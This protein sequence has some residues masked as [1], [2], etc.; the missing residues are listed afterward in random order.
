MHIRPERPEDAQSIANLTTAAFLN[1]SHSGGNEAAV[2]DALRDAGALIISLVA[3]DDHDAIIGHVA[4]SSIEMNGP[5]GSWFALGP[6]SVAPAMQRLGVGSS[7]IREGL[8]RSE[9]LGAAGCVLTGEPAYYDRFGF[10]SNERLTIFGQSSPFLQGLA[11]DGTVITGDI[12][13]HPAFGV[14]M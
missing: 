3:T 5:P 14:G 12:R 6:V 8:A 4:F 2:I 11:F 10:R 9:N 1:A 7:L 13:F